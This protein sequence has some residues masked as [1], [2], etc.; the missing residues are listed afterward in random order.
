MNKT[1]LFIAAVS[2]FLAVAI[3]AFGAHGLKPHISPEAMQ[4]YETGSR[5]HF[6]HTL[7]LLAIALLMKNDSKLLGYAG[8]AFLIGILLFSGSL[9]VMAVTGM[10]KLGMI[11]PIGGV[12]LL[13]GWGMMAIEGLKRRSS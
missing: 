10:K 8:F 4:W 3:G 6:Y 7:A 12:A 9:Y 5:Y 2:G 13:A 1:F 11:T